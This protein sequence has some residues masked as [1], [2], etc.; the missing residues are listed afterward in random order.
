MKEPEYRKLTPLKNEDS[1]FIRIPNHL[2]P[3]G[4][5]VVKI[6]AEEGKLI[7]EFV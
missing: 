5:K 7:L 6:S 1:H 4:K 2:I 3:E